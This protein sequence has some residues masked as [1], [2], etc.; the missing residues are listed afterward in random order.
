M[1]PPSDSISRSSFW[2]SAGDSRA[3]SS[4]AARPREAGSAPFFF[5]RRDGIEGF[6]E[7]SILSRD[8]L[9]H[10]A[11]RIPRRSRGAGAHPS[12]SPADAAPQVRASRSSRREWNS[13]L[14]QAREPQPDELVQGAK[15]DVGP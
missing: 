11:D 10:V 13:R 9:R 7:Q 2:T 8:A 12:L 4:P 1:E 5:F 6:P 3:A 14:G 15:R